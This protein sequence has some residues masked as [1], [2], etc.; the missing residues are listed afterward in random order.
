MKNIKYLLFTA[1][2]VIAV[3]FSMSSCTDGNDWNVEGGDATSNRVFT[4][5]SANVSFDK[6]TQLLTVTW[7]VYE[8]ADYYVLELTNYGRN[9]ND[10]MPEGQIGGTFD[11]VYGRDGSIKSLAYTIPDKLAPGMYQLRLRSC[12]NGKADSHW[13]YFKKN[14][15][16]QF[17]VGGGEEEE[18]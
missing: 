18:E 4:P 11:K 9:I 7:G 17:E 16:Q 6:E 3:T 15:E 13:F 12:T 14:N 8:K 1:L 5:Y 10:N 2:T